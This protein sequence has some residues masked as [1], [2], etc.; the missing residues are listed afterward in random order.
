MVARSSADFNGLMEAAGE[1]LATRVRALGQPWEV[2]L[3]LWL[4]FMFFGVIF[5][6]DLHFRKSLGDWEIFRSAALAVTHGHS[7]FSAANPASLA[8]NDKFVYPPITALLVAPLA[9]LPDEAGRVLVLLLALACVPLALRLLGVQDWRC[10]GLALLTA[11]VLDT[12]S[13]GALSSAMFLGVAAAWRYRDRPYVAGPITGLTSVAKLFAWPLFVW[14][15]ATRRYRAAVAAAAL[16]VPLIVGGWAVIGFAGL[17][18]YPHLLRVLSRVEAVQSYS[19]VGLLRLGGGAAAALTGV[20][21][22][23]VITAV[24]LAARGPDGDR[25]SLTVA[26]AGALLATP[27]LWLHYLVLLFVPIA[28]ARPR[29][30]ALWFAPLAFWVTPLAHSNGS[31][32]RTCFALAVV[33]AILAR[34]LGP[35]ASNAGERRSGLGWRRRALAMPKAA[36]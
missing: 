6:A 12:V 36:P 18:G 20:L 27:V 24:V 26:V 17:T 32:W 28:L 9:V 1:R 13:L 15:V 3:F 30:S 7:P 21:V 10:Y 19:L 23:G 4:P 25:R 11:P 16:A 33:A 8:R 2:A 5:A 34:T 35:A 29:L 31:V 14:L 22:I